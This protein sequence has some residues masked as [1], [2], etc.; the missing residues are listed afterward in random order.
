VVCGREVACSP[1]NTPHASGGAEAGV[2]NE[3]RNWEMRCSPSSA[4]MRVGGGGNACFTGQV[5]RVRKTFRQGV[6]L[7]ETAVRGCQ[8]MEEKWQEVA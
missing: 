6:R 5:R 3:Q 8:H 2:Y 7:N 4:S 1:F